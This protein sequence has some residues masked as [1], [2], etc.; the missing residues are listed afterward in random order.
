VYDLI[1][2][3]KLHASLRKSF[4][5]CVAQCNVVCIETL[6]QCMDAL[7]EFTLLYSMVYA[8][9]PCGPCDLVAVLYLLF[10]W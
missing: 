4:K 3:N 1:I 2:N 10:T 5:L 8:S 9:T 7:C 6:V